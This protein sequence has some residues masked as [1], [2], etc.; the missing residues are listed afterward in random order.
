MRSWRM[1]P[2]LTTTTIRHLRELIAALDW[3]L[4]QVQ[5]IGEAKIAQDAALLKAA[6]LARIAELQ[7]TLE[8][9]PGSSDEPARAIDERP[10]GRD[11]R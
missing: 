7:L 10:E 2:T 4:P 8:A 11:L 6:A 9:D 1:T 3:R 5:R